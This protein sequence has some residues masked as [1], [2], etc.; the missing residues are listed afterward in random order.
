MG[1]PDDRRWRAGRDFRAPTCAA[2]HMSAAKTVARTHD[3]TERLSWGTQAPLTVRPSE[4]APFPAA[5]DW[6][7]ERAKMAA[8]CLQCHSE[9]WT[10]GH[11]VNLD[12]VIRNYNETYY[13]PIK[14]LI[15]GLYRGGLLSKARYFDEDLEWEFY[16]FWHHEGRRARMGAAMMAPDYAWWHGFYELKRRFGHII[17]T[18]ATLRRQ[19]SVRSYREGP[20]TYQKPQ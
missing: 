19:G 13:R 18:A 9:T 17:E 14:N 5:T 2:C 1:P 16:E 15:D 8:V 20:G 6:E 12:G 4:F 3:V 7:E 10:R 11:F